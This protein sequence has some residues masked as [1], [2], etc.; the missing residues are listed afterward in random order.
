M[1]RI[2]VFVFVLSL[3]G[4]LAWFAYFATVTGRVFERFSAV[5]ALALTA[6][7]SG[8]VCLT[9]GLLAWHYRLEGG[10]A[11]GEEVL[12]RACMMVSAGILLYSGVWGV[13]LYLF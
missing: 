9:S 13:F 3:L 11:S 7:L 12:F 4:L 8:G 6:V 10:Y 2:L 1:V 5:E